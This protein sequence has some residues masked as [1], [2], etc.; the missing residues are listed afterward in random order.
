M[1]FYYSHNKPQSNLI[2]VHYITFYFAICGRCLFARF[3]M[4]ILCYFYCNHNGN[5]WKGYKLETPLEI[6]WNNY[7]CVYHWI[8]GQ[9]VVRMRQSVYFG[10]CNSAQHGNTMVTFVDT[11]LI[12]CIL[13]T[14][15]MEWMCEQKGTGCHRMWEL[16]FVSY[17]WMNNRWKEPF[18]G[19][20]ENGGTRSFE[21]CLK[22]TKCLFH[23]KVI[24]LMQLLAWTYVQ[25]CNDQQN[26]V[27]ALKCWRVVEKFLTAW[28]DCNTLQK[29]KEE[30]FG[31]LQHA[32]KRNQIYHLFSLFPSLISS[33]N[34]FGS[35]IILQEELW[36]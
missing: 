23:M 30:N 35:A 8:F 11:Y 19:T 34:T 9:S 1:L 16:C 21:N 36:A 12:I 5:G 14:L 33:C 25:Q 6:H 28:I 26:I 27:K 3:K 4:D 20:F 29:K 18:L 2:Y 13:R 22:A 10:M 15:N 7:I 24:G 32:Y 31:N 17:K